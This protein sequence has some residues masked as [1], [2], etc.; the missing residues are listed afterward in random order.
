MAPFSRG[1]EPKGETSQAK[2]PVEGKQEKRQMGQGMGEEVLGEKKAET[3]RSRPSAWLQ[4]LDGVQSDHHGLVVV[5]GS[6]QRLV[7]AKL[8]TN[9]HCKQPSVRRASD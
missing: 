4:L 6:V 2:S 9:D 7:V 5:F 8:P 3:T 1:D